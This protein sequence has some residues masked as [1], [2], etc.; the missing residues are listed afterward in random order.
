MEAVTAG[1]SNG[2]EPT[3]AQNNANS[4]AGREVAGS[5][6]AVDD[7]GLYLDTELD[8]LLTSLLEEI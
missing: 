6:S 8:D 5:L 1:P 4:I 7:G 3:A 2:G